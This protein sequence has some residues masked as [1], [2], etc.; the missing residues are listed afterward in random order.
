ML[1]IILLTISF[2]L[3]TCPAVVARQVVDSAGRTVTLPDRISRVFPAGPPAAVMVYVVAPDKLLG[4]HREMSPA[5][6]AFLLP[7]AGE[8]PVVGRLTGRGGTIEP[9]ALEALKPDLIIDVGNI[10]GRYVSLADRVQKETGIPYVLIDGSLTQTPESLQLMGT[11]LD[12]SPRAEKL[13]SFAGPHF[14]SLAA[15]LGT[16]QPSERPRIYYGKG[17]DGLEPGFQASINT[18]WIELVGGTNVATADG[19]EATAKVS[20]DQIR[21]WDPQVIVAATP[22][23]AEAVM[24]NPEWSDITA[25]RNG[26][27]FQPP[28]LPFGWLDQPPGINRLIGLSWLKA[29]LFPARKA[30]NIRSEVHHFFKLFYQVDLSDRQMDQILG[31]AP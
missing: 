31:P 30:E 18:E 10:D 29:K 8:L 7:E 14:R 21:E 25:L 28:A 9:A 24:E 2:M 6:K 17:E 13:A 26:M 15:H 1:K 23:F 16:L 22:A 20:V 5:E 3:I 27:V 4:W 11:V 12:V 19:M